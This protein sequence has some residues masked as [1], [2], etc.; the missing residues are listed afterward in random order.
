MVARGISF[1]GVKDCA[2]DLPEEE[3]VNREEAHIIGFIGR[4]GNPTS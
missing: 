2:H 3:V 1:L 4:Q